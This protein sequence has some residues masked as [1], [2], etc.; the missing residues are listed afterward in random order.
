MY[1]GT[2][3][4]DDLMQDLCI[5][6]LGDKPDKFDA[7][8]ERGE[9]WYYLVRTIKIAA[10]SKTTP[11]YRKYKK[12][13]EHID[14]NWVGIEDRLPDVHETYDI[15]TDEWTQ[16]KLGTIQ[17]V[18]KDIPWF[19]AEL[20]KIYYLHEHT[21][22]TLSDATGINKNT[23][24]KGISRAKRKIRKTLKDKSQEYAQKKQV[25]SAWFG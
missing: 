21:L 18:L 7:I 19:E 14:R 17:E 1:V 24:N 23:I 2:D 9:L 13:K 22:Q 12:H 25:K 20:F 4:G 8:C 10:F 3:L 16:Q 11:F 6:V 15:K 5:M